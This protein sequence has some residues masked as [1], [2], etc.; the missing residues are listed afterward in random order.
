MASGS[1]QSSYDPYDSSSDDEEYL[2]LNNV[3][4]TTLGKSDRAAH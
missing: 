2:I 4:E 3:A 1:E